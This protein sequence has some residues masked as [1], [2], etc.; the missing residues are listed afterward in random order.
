MTET[1]PGAPDPVTDD[2]LDGFVGY[3]M[4]RAFAAVQ[5][6]LA[7]TLEPFELRMMTFS[8]LVV[9]VDNPGLRQSD[10][11]QAL[12]VERPNL[13]V[14]VDELERRGLIRRQQMPTDRRAYAL[15][16]TD[17]GR[18]LCRRATA[19]VK[20]HEDRILSGLSANQIDQ[21]SDALRAIR[22]T[23]EE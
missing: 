11:A 8:A 16:P 5:T 4:K 18:G 2:T 15:V 17:A 7:R 23:A 6:D 21:L 13:V 14:I 22:R 20:A 3:L 10:L 19:A 12:S 9:V 1:A